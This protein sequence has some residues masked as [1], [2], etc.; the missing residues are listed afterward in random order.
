MKEEKQK[1]IEN[2]DITEE[3]FDNA[4]NYLY[5]EYGYTMTMWTYNRLFKEIEN[6]CMCY[7]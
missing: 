4:Y 3:Q 5:E 6:Y 7:D 1:I 2:L